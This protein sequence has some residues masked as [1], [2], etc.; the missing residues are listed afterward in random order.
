MEKSNMVFVSV[1]A[2]KKRPRYI[3]KDTR[4]TVTGSIA[5][6]GSKGEVKNNTRYKIK[7]I[8]DKLAKKHREYRPLRDKYMKFKGCNKPSNDL[9]HKARRG[10]N[11][12]NVETFMAVCRTCHNWIEDNP[13][14]SRELGYLI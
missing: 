5:K 13:T 8:S 3:L 2:P 12:C 4:T 6:K 10:K 11:L 14:K 9:H 1:D 7:P